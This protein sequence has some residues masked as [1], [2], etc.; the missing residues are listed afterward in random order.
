V[1][2]AVEYNPV[3]AVGA[4]CPGVGNLD[5]AYDPDIIEYGGSY[6]LCFEGYCHTA[7]YSVSSFIAHATS[8]TGPFVVT[9]CAVKGSTSSGYGASA[10]NFLKSAVND[11]IFL[12]W[13]YCNQNI[14]V[15][16]HHIAQFPS[17]DL[18]TRISDNCNINLLPQT[19]GWA[20]NN[21]GAASCIYEA[22]YYYMFYEGANNWICAG[23]WGLGFCRTTNIYDLN[24]WVHNPNNPLIWGGLNTSCW[25]GYPKIVKLSG[26]YYMYYN[27][28]LPNWPN[29]QPVYRRKVQ[30]NTAA[31]FNNDGAVDAKDLNL[32][33]QSWLEGK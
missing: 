24:S 33:T 20:V 29:P 13:P 22:P 15:T 21:F 25:V 17:N 8:I 4:N 26:K 1:N 31:D 23:Q 6:W 28:G 7:G 16:G 18:T 3:V 19:T 14:H 9:S 10:P 2:F 27:N 5:S 30:I 12:S 11:D 32:L